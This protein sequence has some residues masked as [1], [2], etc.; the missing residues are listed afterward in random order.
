MAASECLSLVF[1]NSRK[2]QLDNTAEEILELLIT[3]LLK[4]QIF[5]SKFKNSGF[6]SVQREKFWTKI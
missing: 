5:Q 4:N 1:N 3:K 6:K 2:K